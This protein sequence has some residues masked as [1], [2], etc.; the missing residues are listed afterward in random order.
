[1]RFIY[2]FL[3]RFI[4]F[5]RFI[6]NRIYVKRLKPARRDRRVLYF[7]QTFPAGWNS[8]K[9]LFLEAKSRSNLEIKILV[10]P[11]DIDDANLID[12]DLWLDTLKLECGKDYI[13]EAFDRKNGSWFDISTVKPDYIFYNRPYEGDLINHAYRPS[14][15]IRYSKTYFLHY[16]Y[17]LSND[18]SKY[19]RNDYFLYPNIAESLKALT[20]SLYLELFSAMLGYKKVLNFGYPRFELLGEDIDSASKTILYTPRWNFSEKAEDLSSFLLFYPVFIKW[21]HDNQDYSLVIRPHP[22]LFKSL[23]RDKGLSIQDV[24][25][26]KASLS[27]HINIVIDEEKD[28]LPSIRKAGLVVTDY[29]ALIAEYYYSQKDIV[30]FGR[31]S[32]LNSEARNIFKDIVLVEN[33]VELLVLLENFKSGARPK[34]SKKEY[35][36]QIKS[37]KQIID[38]L[39]N[40]KI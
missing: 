5:A 17:S 9:P 32:H 36:K 13:I 11:I 34:A 33:E 25:E 6:S 16:G 10:C 35:R 27:E 24:Q 7:V 4:S 29:T 12:Y 23:I 19:W 21:M 30:Y 15:A 1:M 40:E 37:S 18:Y 20:Y 28:Y 22:W 31:T 38:Y 39:I 3:L 2:Y 14:N 8:V 26:I